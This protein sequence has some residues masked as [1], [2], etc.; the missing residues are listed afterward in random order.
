MHVYRPCGSLR[1]A[2]GLIW[3]GASLSEG[4]PPAITGK[5]ELPSPPLFQHKG[6]K[7]EVGLRIS[8]DFEPPLSCLLVLVT[9]SR[10]DS[11]KHLFCFSF[12]CQWWNQRHVTSPMD[13]QQTI[14][15]VNMDGTGLVNVAPQHVNFLLV[16]I[17]VL[18]LTS[19]NFSHCNCNQVRGVV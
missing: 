3:T 1:R 16:F 15:T 4:P 10:A 5:F 12:P 14:G 11:V 18:Q 9:P 8:E 7:N 2:F 19:A 17:A 13:Q 6:S